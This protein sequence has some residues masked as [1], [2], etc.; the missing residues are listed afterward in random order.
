[1]TLKMTRVAAGCLCG[2]GVLLLVGCSEGG[3][4]PTAP[5]A[6]GVAASAGP[7]A[8]IETTNA[9]VGATAGSARPFKGTLALALVGEPE[10]VPPSTV[11]AHLTG[12]GTATHLGRFTATLDVEIDVSNE[13]QETSHGAMTL[14]A[15][16]GDTIL[17]NV[18]G[19][20]SVDGDVTTIVESVL[21]TGGTGRFSAASGSFVINRQSTAEALLPAS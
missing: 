17:G 9:S 14:T 13:P 12:T 18:T 16:N 15:A 20:A 10:F 21:I 5:S 7:R 19:H 4:V 6:S 2:A 1:M 3:R 8:E 11:S